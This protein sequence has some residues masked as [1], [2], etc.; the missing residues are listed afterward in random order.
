MKSILF[1]WLALFSFFFITLHAQQDSL[2]SQ[3]HL[4]EVVVSSSRI[5]LDFSENSRTLHLISAQELKS[6]GALTVVTALQQIAGID[7]RQRGIAGIQADLYIRGGGFDQTLILID[8]IKLDD[9]QTGHHTLNFLPPIEVIEQIEIVKGPAAR[10]FGQNAFTGA[11]NIVTKK[12]FSSG[13]SAQLRAGSYGQIH[14]EINYRTTSEKG[15]FLA[16]FSRNSADG[17]RY[18]SDFKNNTFFLKAGLFKGKKLPIDI[19]ASFN[20]RKFGANGFYASPDAIDQYEETEG[21]VLAVQ[22]KTQ[23]GNWIFKPRVYWRRGQDHYLY[24]R[25]NPKIYENWHITHK[26]GTALDVSLTSKLGTTGMGFDLSRV[27]IVSNNLGNRSRQLA[28]FFLE[29]RFTFWGQKLD[30]TPGVAVN[31]Y[32]DFGNFAY[33]GIDIGVQFSSQFRLYG[34]VGYTYRIPTYTDMYYSDRTTIGNPDLKPEEALTKE[35]G[36]RFT[37]NQFTFYVAYFDRQA[38]NLIDYVRSTGDNLWEATNIRSIDTQGFETEI[39]YPFLIDKKAQSLKFGYTYLYDNLRETAANFSRYS[40]NSLQHHFTSSYRAQLTDKLKWFTGFK[41]A[42]R[43][44]MEGYTV[45]DSNLQW[46]LNLFQLTA[47]INNLLNEKYSETNL[48][49]MPGRNV[50]FS[51]QYQL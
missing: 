10:V 4:K 15:N 51:L 7:I 29:Q 9:V 34:N 48:V 1:K 20:G 28:T 22:T 44:S 42:K 40:I 37:S 5:D 50:L 38:E 23:R 49:P 27:S 24:I 3:Q 32:S 31:M 2:V 47:S 19:L 6:S 35:L 36:L 33:P 14:G 46:S 18:N 17:Y 45:I 8:G 12:E 39:N 11:I 30:F 41:Y 26:V 25:S 16:H 43:S 21:S 13:G